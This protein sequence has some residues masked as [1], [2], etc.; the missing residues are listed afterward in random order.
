MG[1]PPSPTPLRRGGDGGGGRRP[2]PLSHARTDQ[3]GA[4]D[5]VSRLV[6][7]VKLPRRAR[8]LSYPSPAMLRSR[9]ERSRSRD[10]V[11]APAAERSR[12][13]PTA[14]ADLL[15]LA[16]WAYDPS[17]NTIGRDC[18]RL[19]QRLRSAAPSGGIRILPNVLSDA[20]HVGVVQAVWPIIAERFPCLSAEEDLFVEHPRSRDGGGQ[21][22]VITLARL[23]ADWVFS[24][25][26]LNDQ[27]AARVRRRL[28]RL[29]RQLPCWMDGGTRE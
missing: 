9:A 1:V 19:M 11:A 10:G 12:S 25:I 16:G 17:F 21:V 15:S 23:P 14:S 26:R 13:R 3:S 27:G 7:W 22:Y 8:A 2:I 4:Q 5:G 24:V 6:F 20:E 28:L 18:L 29:R